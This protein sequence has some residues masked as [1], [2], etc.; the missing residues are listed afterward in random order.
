MKPHEFFHKY[1]NTPLSERGKTITHDRYGSNIKSTTLSK[2]YQRIKDIEDK[3][4]PDH[5]ELEKLLGIAED[6][7]EPPEG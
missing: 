5:I 1:A 4:R 7:W 3:I 2:L 6:Y